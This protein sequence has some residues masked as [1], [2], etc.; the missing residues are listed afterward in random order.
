MVWLFPTVVGRSFVVSMEI[1]LGQFRSRKS[2]YTKKTSAP[3][4]T[5]FTHG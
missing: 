3:W 5:L 1:T 4:Q 2:G